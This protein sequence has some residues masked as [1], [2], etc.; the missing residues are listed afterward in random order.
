MSKSKVSVKVRKGD[1]G[2]ALRIFKRLVNESEHIQ[3]LK[4]RREYIKPTTKRRLIKQNAR[5]ENQRML[6][7]LRSEGNHH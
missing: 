5:R 4:G 6:K 7:E 2:K 1:I 3:E